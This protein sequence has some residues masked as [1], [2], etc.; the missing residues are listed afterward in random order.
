MKHWIKLFMYF[1]GSLLS[2]SSR[3]KVLYY[4]DVTPE[5]GDAHTDMSTPFDLFASHMALVEQ[6]GFRFVSKITQ[7]KGEVMIAF[8]DGFHGVYDNKEFFRAH[9]ICP[10]VF[11]AT[12]L[13]GKEGYLN[14]AEIRELQEQGFVFQCH[15]VSHT[16]LQKFSDEELKHEVEDSK[17]ELEALL[18]KDV[19]EICF[20]QGYFSDRVVEACRRAGYRKMYTSIPGDYDLKSDMV[21]RD[22]CQFESVKTF[23]MILHG[24]MNLL[25]NHYRKLHYLN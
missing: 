18:G 7:S 22:L 25:Q 12:T 20:P 19:D 13:I 1:V 6:D 14:E 15:T 16:N 3:S 23:K 9:N 24:G 11:L 5:K 8:D 4:H 17:R 2:S 10:T 21:R